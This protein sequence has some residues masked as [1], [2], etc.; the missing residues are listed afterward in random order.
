MQIV[1]V[2]LV[3]DRSMTALGTMLMIVIRVLM[4]HSRDYS[5]GDSSVGSLPCA[6]PFSIK[7]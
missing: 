1:D 3:L 5:S 7:C 6:I 4:T 2:I